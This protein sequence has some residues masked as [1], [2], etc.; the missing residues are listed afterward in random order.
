MLH[1]ARDLDM[2]RELHI[3]GEDP[4]WA[5]QRASAEARRL[6]ISRQEYSGR[7]FRAEELCNVGSATATTAR[8]RVRCRYD[9]IEG[10]R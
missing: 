1:P 10:T 6:G 7:Q 8:E 5:D 3:V 4:A 9:V 2:L